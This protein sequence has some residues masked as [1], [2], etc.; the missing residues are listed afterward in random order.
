MTPTIPHIRWTPCAAAALALAALAGLASRGAQASPPAP[1]GDEV[2]H[3]VKEGDTLE[4]LARDYLA[5]PRQWQQ[6]QDWGVQDDPQ[7]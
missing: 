1:L 7:P 2:A 3:I 5:A 4:G 6:L